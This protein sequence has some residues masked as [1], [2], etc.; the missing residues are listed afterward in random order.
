MVA[1]LESS[2]SEGRTDFDQSGAT[3]WRWIVVLWVG[4][5]EMR[6]GLRS[7]YIEVDHFQTE[8][9]LAWHLQTRLSAAMCICDSI[10]SSIRVMP[11]CFNAGVRLECSNLGIITKGTTRLQYV[12]T[13]TTCAWMCDCGW[14]LFERRDAEGQ[15]QKHRVIYTPSR[16]RDAG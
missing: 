13:R 10:P 9:Y 6:G 5:D 2:E 8:C 4:L 14:A 3:R 12:N 7:K 15:R 11:L 16:L 1:A